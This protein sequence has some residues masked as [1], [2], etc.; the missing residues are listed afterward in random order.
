MRCWMICMMSATALAY[1]FNKAQGGLDMAGDIRLLEQ[2]HGITFLEC[3][4]ACLYTSE[5]VKEWERLWKKKLIPSTPL[6]RMID[7]ATGYDMAVMGEFA[8]FVYECVFHIF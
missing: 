5:F 6:D 8:D 3:L 7:S 1:L 2:R 4:E